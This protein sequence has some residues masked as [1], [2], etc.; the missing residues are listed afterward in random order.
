VLQDPSLDARL[1]SDLRDYHYE[2]ELDHRDSRE[3]RESWARAGD[4]P[5]KG[6]C[7]ADV[8]GGQGGNGLILLD[9]EA[10][11]AITCNRCTCNG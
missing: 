11:W 3:D 7:G 8:E 4:D 1:A 5:T 6:D 2:D 10:G 9:R